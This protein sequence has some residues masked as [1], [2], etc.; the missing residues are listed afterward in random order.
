MLGIV[1]VV[2]EFKKGPR[3]AY[4]YPSKD[5]EPSSQRIFGVA[6]RS[7]SRVSSETA[8]QTL[9]ERYASLEDENFAK[10][11]R[12][13]PANRLFEITIG[14][15]EF[16]SY[17][18][19]CPKSELEESDSANVHQLSMFTL[20]FAS[21]S[22]AFFRRISLSPKTKCD[23][24]YCIVGNPLIATNCMHD[25][26][27]LVWKT[28]LERILE[29]ASISLLNE[30][31]RSRYLTLQVTRMLRFFE[32]Q[33]QVFLSLHSNNTIGERLLIL[34]IFELTS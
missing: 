34:F 6:E 5:S 30:E 25:S 18:C 29:V 13:P 4:R 2:H 26:S 3:I 7:E 14:D 31:K 20:V 8:I 10:L 32:N 27:Q 1:L 33:D 16:I 17:A 11:F 21:A 23:N 28:S 19:S 22:P 9:L 15:I 24:N 12:K